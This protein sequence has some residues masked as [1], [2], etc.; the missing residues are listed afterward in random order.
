VSEALADLATQLEVAATRLGEDD[1]EAEEAA[2]LATHAA[3][4]A[5]QAAI[6]LERQARGGPLEQVPGQEELL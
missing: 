2:R 1:L 3:E 6:E 4:L 5:S